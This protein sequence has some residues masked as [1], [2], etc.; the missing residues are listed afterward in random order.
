LPDQERAGERRAVV[1][2]T[3]GTLLDRLTGACR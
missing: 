3:V 1:L 2:P